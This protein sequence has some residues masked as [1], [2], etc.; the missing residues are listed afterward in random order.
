M[1]TSWKSCY[2][3][4]DKYNERVK[5]V[6]TAWKALQDNSTPEALDMVKRSNEFK[7]YDGESCIE[8]REI[9]IHV[10]GD[11]MGWEGNFKFKD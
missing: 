6:Q 5:A 9:E 2:S 10:S 3:E 8:A 11:F 4:A 7:I 1:I